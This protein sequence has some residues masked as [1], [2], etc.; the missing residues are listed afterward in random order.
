MITWRNASKFLYLFLKKIL[1]SAVS[2]CWNLSEENICFNSFNNILTYFFC[3]FQPL[4]IANFL[5]CK[6]IHEVI[7]DEK[8]WDNSTRYVVNRCSCWGIFLQSVFWV[9]WTIFGDYCSALDKLV[10]ISP[11]TTS[12]LTMLLCCEFGYEIRT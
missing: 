10:C 7:E 5:V 6:A 4:N 12:H 8:I 3:R 2:N 11:V 1:I 9:K